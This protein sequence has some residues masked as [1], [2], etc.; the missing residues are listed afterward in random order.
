MRCVISRVGSS[1][2]VATR[3]GLKKVGL[4]PDKDV[5]LIQVGS[6]QARTAA[7]LSGAIQG[8]AA[9]PP[10]TLT[11]EDEGFHPVIDLA[12]L[13]LPA[14]NN[15]ISSTGAWSAAHKDEVQRYVDS[16]VESINRMKKDRA[17]GIDVLKRNLKM[18]DQRKLDA[19]YDYWITKSMPS[20]PYAD[21]KQFPDSVDAVASKNP[22]A[23]DYDL[24]KLIDSSYMKSAADRG[25]DKR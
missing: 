12:E 2:D 24:N 21:A 13:N 4:D 11:L 10:D 5:S 22:K 9:N 16:V 7:M 17:F 18:D 14:T 20:L 1:S 6:L 15:T 25:V 23:K 19:T 3:A 8:A